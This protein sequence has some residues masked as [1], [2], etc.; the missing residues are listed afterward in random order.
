MTMSRDLEKPDCFG[1]LHRVFP[2]G[3]DGLRH[4]PDACMACIHKTDCLRTAI[5]NPDGL[6]V[7]EEV[8]DRAY[9]AKN[10][11]FFERWSRRKYLSR[12]KGK[13]QEGE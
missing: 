4:S 9:A 1:I 3:D 5:A 10:I 11:G 2:L 8:V 6:K 12:L 7:R 13:K